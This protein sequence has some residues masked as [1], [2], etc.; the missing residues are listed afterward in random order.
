VYFVVNINENVKIGNQH[1]NF[2]NKLLFTG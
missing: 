1:H 2:F